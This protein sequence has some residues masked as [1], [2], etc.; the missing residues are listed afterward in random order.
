MFLRRDYCRVCGFAK[1]KI[2][3]IKS[4][5]TDE[6]LLPV[7]DLGL[8]PPPNDFKR[9]TD[10]HCGFYPLKVLF[11][12]RCGLAQL[13]VAVDPVELYGN[14]AYTT[15]QSKTMQ[16]HFLSLITQIKAVHKLGN[17]LEIGSNDGTFLEFLKNNGADKVIGID[18]AQNLAAIANWRGLNTIPEMFN[19]SSG[20]RVKQQLGKIDTIFAR[21]VFCHMDDW[22][23]LMKT[24]RAVTH[25]GSLIVIEVPYAVDLL[26]NTELDTIYAEH[27]SY[28]SLKPFVT[29]LA[30]TPFYLHDVL[31]LDIHGGA[32]AL[33]V[34]QR[35][36]NGTTSAMALDMFRRE[37]IKRED[38][39][40][41]STRAHK[42][43]A[44][45][46]DTIRRLRSE[47]KRVAGYGAPAKSTVWINACGFTRNDLE[48]VTDTTPGKQWTFVP[49]TD[50]PVTDPGALILE[51]PDYCVLW[52]WNYRI[53][54]LAKE[55]YYVEHGGKFIVPVPQVEIYPK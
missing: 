43:I 51:M 30:N 31:P 52:S 41:F 12:P 25:D 22:Q 46:R 49:G 13:S 14:Y 26:R 4:L 33:L 17:V 24:L 10:P 34:K 37:D 11:C 15:S 50:I 20:T 8:Q 47:G 44:N 35:N 55:T 39:R 40:D 45:L 21:H 38:W 18:P 28:L 3:H 7:F 5:Q 42:Q 27:L 1:N 2:D 16:E 54:I 36:L 19:E 32:I 29:L 9:A 48:F 23:G 6:H 53:E